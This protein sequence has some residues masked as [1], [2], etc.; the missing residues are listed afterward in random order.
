VSIGDVASR[1]GELE[2][3]SNEVMDRITVG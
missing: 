1:T 3:D 2:K